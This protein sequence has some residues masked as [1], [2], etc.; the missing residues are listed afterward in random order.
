MRFFVFTFFV[1]FLREG[2]VPGGALIFLML[3]TFTSPRFL[4]RVVGASG[5][6]KGSGSSQK[7]AGGQP[8]TAAVGGC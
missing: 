3:L 5:V 1:A 4:E 8:G 7:Y 6:R 2:R